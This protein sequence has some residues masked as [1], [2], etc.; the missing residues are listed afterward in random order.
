MLKITSKTLKPNTENLVKLLTVGIPL[1]RAMSILG[2]DVPD[3]IRKQWEANADIRDDILREAQLE[4]AY[5]GNQSMLS[6]LGKQYL[7]QR[8]KI[9]TDETQEGIEIEVS[10]AKD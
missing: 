9:D 2:V 6:W 3:D 4:L 10:L 1:E 5:N 8:D 7:N